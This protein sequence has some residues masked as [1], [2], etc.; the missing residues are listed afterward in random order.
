MSP[1][2]IEQLYRAQRMRA[3]RR[4]RRLVGDLAE[5]VVQDAFAHLATPHAE[6]LGTAPVGAWLDRVLVNRCLSELR[7]RRP[8]LALEPPEPERDAETR[9]LAAEAGHLCRQGLSSLG[10]RDREIIALHDL[11]SLT[12]PEIA[13]RLGI[14]EGTVKS[15]LHRARGKL[16]RALAAVE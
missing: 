16:R 3:V 1:E 6:Y 11:E 12:Y 4:L 10:E 14:A 7:K 15:R 13:E 8:S 9:Y 5:D 2:S